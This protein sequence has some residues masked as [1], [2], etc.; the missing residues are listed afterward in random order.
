MAEVIPVPV[1][2]KCK[3]L[4][5]PRGFSPATGLCWFCLVVRP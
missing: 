3:E 2:K 5:W 1:C 4:S